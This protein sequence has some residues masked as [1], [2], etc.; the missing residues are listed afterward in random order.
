MK[1]LAHFVVSRLNSF[2]VSM[3][4]DGASPRELYTGIKPDF[5][6]DVKDLSFGDY[7]QAHQDFETN[8][9]LPR[10]RTR[11]YIALYPKGNT[12]GT[13]KLY[14]LLIHQEI[15][16]RTWTKLRI[17]IKVIGR[18]NTL[19]WYRRRSVRFTGTLFRGWSII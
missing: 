10:E 9:N 17:P 15:A 8:T 18:I 5:E 12:L 6:K 2:P 4:M 3:Q 11:G 7:V 13:L 1:G 14:S 19:V 16:R